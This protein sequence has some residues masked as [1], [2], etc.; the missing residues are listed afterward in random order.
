MEYG[1]LQK[2]YKTIM[3]IVLVAI[4]TFM[5]TTVGIY[6][7]IGDT[8]NVKYVLVGGDANNSNSIG[9]LSKLKTAVEKYY[10]GEYDEKTMN[11][12]AAKGYIAGLGDEYSEYITAEEYEEFSKEVYG[13]FVGIGIYFGKDVNGKMV[14]VEPIGNSPAE[15]AGLLAGDYIT[16]VD[17]Y[18]VTDEST[19]TDVSDRIKGKEGTKV[20]IEILREENTFTFEI[21]RENVKLHYIETEV[22][23]NNIGYI[24]VSSFDSGTADE[25]KTK[26]EDLLAKK[27]KSLIIDLR[28]NGGGIVQ[29]ATQI[30]DYLLDKDKTI[31][32]TKDKAGNQEITKTKQNKLTDLP[33]VVIT[34]AQSAS[35][36]EILVSA[37]KD[38]ER[39]KVVG[40]KTYGKGV[41]QNVYKLSDGSA[42]KLTTDEYY[43]PLGD[44]INGIGITPTETVELPD[45]VNIYSVPREKDT[46]LDKAIEV[47][48]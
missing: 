42:L 41:I 2:V 25:F 29:E 43:T 7:K 44:K 15:K 8:S 32:I 26:L 20:K 5:I 46:Q 30:A 45:G 17:D 35:A 13:S 39:A 21:I 28:N 14:I 23:E 47:L 34:N 3:L 12:Y 9:I 40:I 37:L 16:K 38:N 11:D 31:I 18:V 48:K 19:T 36:S 24:S 6:N 33:I 27:V 22:L 1:K 4:I 10:L